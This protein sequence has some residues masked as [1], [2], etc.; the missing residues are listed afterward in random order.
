MQWPYWVLNPWPSG[1]WHSASVTTLPSEAIWKGKLINS[2]ALWSCALHERPP[3]VKP[4]DSFPALYGAW[5]SVTEFT[6]ALH[7]SLSWARPIQSTSPHPTSPR[8]ILMLSIHLRLG[9]P[10]CLFPS[11]FPSNNLYTFLFCLSCY[12]LCSSHPPQLDHSNYIWRRVQIRKL[13]VM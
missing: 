5:R 9:L 11:D 3:V 10:S 13:L 8:S 7:L 2:I 12:M 6:R 4:L 1:L